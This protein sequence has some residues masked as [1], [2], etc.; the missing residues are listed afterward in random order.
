MFP[1]KATELKNFEL[2]SLPK[3][4]DFVF[5]KMPSATTKWSNSSTELFDKDRLSFSPYSIFFNST[6]FIIFSDGILLSKKL[7]KIDLLRVV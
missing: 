1:L 6:F 4:I 2:V 7:I 3:I 5:E